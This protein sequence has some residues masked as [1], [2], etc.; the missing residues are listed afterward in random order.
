MHPIPNTIVKISIVFFFAAPIFIIG[1]CKK[2]GFTRLLDVE[3]K[4]KIVPAAER[5]K[6]GDTVKI[7][8]WL[9]YKQYDRATNSTVD[10]RGMEIQSWGSAIFRGLDSLSNGVTVKKGSHLYED[11]FTVTHPYGTFR[12]YPT[13]H[14][15]GTMHQND[16]AFYFQLNLVAKT[17]WVFTI[18]PIGGRGFMD[19]GRFRIDIALR[20]VNNNY[21]QHLSRKY[22]PNTV[23]YDEDYFFETY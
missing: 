22:Q 12:E 19:K 4:Y 21:H 13:N 10:I 5:V 6:V 3:L 14:R 20:I 8:A 7:I 17:P 16:T 2:E 1:G 11:F 23:P 18:R 15:I 9:P